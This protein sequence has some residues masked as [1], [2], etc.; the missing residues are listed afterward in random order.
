MSARVK[1]LALKQIG[2]TIR[3]ANHGSGSAAG[4]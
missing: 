2:T 1:S 3:G 4:L